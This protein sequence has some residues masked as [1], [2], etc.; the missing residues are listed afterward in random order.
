[1]KTKTSAK[2]KKS[3]KGLLILVFVCL[4]GSIRL[5][6]LYAFHSTKRITSKG[7]LLG[8][9]VESFKSPLSFHGDECSVKT[10]RIQ[11]HSQNYFTKPLSTFFHYPLAPLSRKIFREIVYVKNGPL[12][13]LRKKKQIP[14]KIRLK[15]RTHQLLWWKRC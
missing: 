11:N 8:K 5:Y 13:F 14:Y 4:L 3:L 6:Y 7:F 2:S 12:E 10:F 1:M 15:I 9:P